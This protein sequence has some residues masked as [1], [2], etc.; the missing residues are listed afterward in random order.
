ML[1]GAGLREFCG[2]ATR[3]G[4]DGKASFSMGAL[5]VALAAEGGLRGGIGTVAVAAA[6]CAAGSVGATVGDVAATGTRV[7][8]AA[9][10]AGRAGAG[11]E[12]SLSA[13]RKKV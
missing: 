4:W 11:A 13:L 8:D 2:T 12:M 5:P 9:R 7:L 6:L 3:V 1:A 10:V